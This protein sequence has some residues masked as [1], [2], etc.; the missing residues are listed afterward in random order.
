LFLM[1]R[2]RVSAVSNYVGPDLA[3]GPILRDAA[4]RPRLSMTNILEVA[5]SIIVILRRPPGA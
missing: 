3:R 1:V 5:P 4:R 2:R